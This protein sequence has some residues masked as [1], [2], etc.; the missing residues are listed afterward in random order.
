MIEMP[1]PLVSPGRAATL[2]LTLAA[3]PPLYILVAIQYSAITVPFWDHTELI[4]WITAWN[5]GDFHFSSLWAPHNH[6]RPFVYRFVMVF[7]AALTDWDIR[8]EYI[9]MYL[10]IYGTFACHAWLIG[11]LEA[12]PKHRMIFAVT[13]LL[14]SLVLF[15][16]VG[17]NN[18]W[19]SMMFQLNATHFFIA[20]SFVL[21]FVWPERWA[22]HVV[23]AASCW[24]AVFTL[25]NGFFAMVA[26]IVIFQMSSLRLL[27][28]DRFALFW[29]VNLVLAAA[30][31]LPGITMD[32]SPTHPSILNLVQFSL[33]YLGAPLG[34]LLWF[35][36]RNMTDLP[37]SIAANVTCGILLVATCAALSID[38]WPRL[39]NRNLAAM[40]LFGFVGFAMM[41]AMGTAWARASFDEYGVSNG[42]ASRYTVFGAYMMLGQIYYLATGVA[43]GWWGQ[44]ANRA[45]PRRIVV[46]AIT[47]FIVL[48]FVTY[49][50]ATRVYADAHQFNKMLSQAYIWGLQ[51]TAEDKYLHPRPEFVTYLKREL[52]LLE[53]G[54]YANRTYAR[55]QTVGKFVL[56]GFLSA[57]RKITQRF[58]ASD[59]G[60]KSLSFKFVRPNGD[61]TQ[62]TVTWL[63]TEVGSSLPIASGSFDAR[64]ARD[65]VPVRLKLPYIEASKNK[66]YELN[67]SGTGDEAHALGIP[68]YEQVSTSDPPVVVSDE[69]DAL[70]RNRVTMDLTTEYA[71]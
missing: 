69:N 56:A 48:C 32:T 14:S 63:L 60:L 16:P 30:C 35:P 41:S 8:S 21:V 33:A 61:A 9:Y 34:G 37:S 44:S 42:N 23:A 40:M 3:V 66:A 2:L 62:G 27:R 7:N 52:Q 15:S 4:R 24:L 17:H 43:Q 5:E 39:R 67:F 58:T 47:I 55:V 11:R 28:P 50:R 19:W 70:W 26:V 57:D 22:G 71:Q 25:T 64:R 53:I 6:T 29:T 18:H 38:A 68:L 20:L 51:P 1:K 54:P 59:G 49:G 46:A 31:Y 65:W 10:A 12:V 45:F 36:Y 13:V